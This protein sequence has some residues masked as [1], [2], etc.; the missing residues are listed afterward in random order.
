MITLK[1]APV[2]TESAKSILK[3]QLNLKGIDVVNIT[4]SYIH[5]LDVRNDLNQDELSKAQKL[6]TYGPNG[7]E[8]PG[9]FKTAIY[10]IPRFG[11]ISLGHRKATDIFKNCGLNNVVRVERAKAFYFDKAFNSDSISDITAII[12]DRM[13]ETIIFKEED[14]SKLLNNMKQKDLRVLIL[15]LG[16]GIL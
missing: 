2:L 14:A 9:E 7:S 15:Y 3:S 12:S 4:T 8:D 10:V 1:G 11:T 16:E 6:L 13:V 5:F